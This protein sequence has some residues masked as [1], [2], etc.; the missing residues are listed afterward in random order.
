MPLAPPPT[1]K[2]FPTFAE[3]IA[4][5]QAHAAREGYAVNS[6]GQTKDKQTGLYKRHVIR[7]DK[8][9]TFKSH[10]QLGTRRIGSKKTDCP[11]SAASTLRPDGCHLKVLV[12]GHNHPPSAIPAAHVQH[13]RFTEEQKRLVETGAM[14]RKSVRVIHEEIK[15]LDPHTYIT[16]KDVDNAVQKFRRMARNSATGV[17]AIMYKLAERQDLYCFT[18]EREGTV[19][20]AFWV[21]RWS[22][23]LWMR[24]NGTPDILVMMAEN[25]SNQPILPILEMNSVLN[26]AGFGSAP[27]P[28]PPTLLQQHSGPMMAPP[29]PVLPDNN[30]EAAAAAAAPMSGGGS[31]PC[32]NSINNLSVMMTTTTTDSPAPSTPAPS[33]PAPAPV[34]P[35]T[36][37]V[38]GAAGAV[39]ITT[40]RTNNGIDPALGAGYAILPDKS[41]GTLAWLLAAVEKLRARIGQAPKPRFLTLTDFHTAEKNILVE[42]SK[43]GV[44]HRQRHVVF[45]RFLDV[46]GGGGEQNSSS[47]GNVHHHHHHPGVG[48]TRRSNLGEY[49]VSASTR[50]IDDSGGVGGGQGVGNVNEI[51]N[52]DDD[53]LDTNNEDEEEQE[54]EQEEDI[55]QELEEE[56]DSDAEIARQLA[57]H[58]HHQ[59]YGNGHANSRSNNHHHHDDN[60]IYQQHQGHHSEY[61]QSPLEQSQQQ[62]HTLHAY[63]QQLHHH[64]PPSRPNTNSRSPTPKPSSHAPVPVVGYTPQMIQ[65]HPLQRP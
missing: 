52:D 59:G 65:N 47:N 16:F 53:G 28:P 63:P 33:T 51:E 32:N 12:P 44:A 49:D 26:I 40:T 3:L 11:F 27:P 17:Q 42:V 35:Q 8:S 4:F 46:T 56:E 7:C 38:T 48:T 6:K 30:P 43:G 57:G 55:D 20:G 31:S 60:D 58:G 10:A 25:V 36:P 45:G 9:G 2:V 5:V 39:P 54:E 37:V 50:V 64:Q 1:D 34:P 41:D 61:P 22:S 21:P 15:M 62:Q 19:Q 13:R 29:T 14:E 18:L 23:E 24:N